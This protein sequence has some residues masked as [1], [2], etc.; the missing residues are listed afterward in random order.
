MKFGSLTFEDGFRCLCCCGVGSCYFIHCG[1]VVECENQVND[2]IYRDCFQSGYSSCTLQAPHVTG[3][4]SH[5]TSSFVYLMKLFIFFNLTRY[6]AAPLFIPPP[7]Q[8][9]PVWGVSHRLEGAL[10]GWG[11]L[12]HPVCHPAA[13]HYDSLATLQQQPGE[14]M[15]GWMS[16]WKLYSS[17]SHTGGK[18]PF[19]VIEAWQGDRE[20]VKDSGNQTFQACTS[21][22]P[23]DWW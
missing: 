9:P 3:C 22:H 2:N 19:V 14:R 20:K 23:T 13:G 10:G 17:G 5:I 6:P 4:W 18:L 15:D 7:T 16:N 21:T 1:Q 11:L 12:A 8:V